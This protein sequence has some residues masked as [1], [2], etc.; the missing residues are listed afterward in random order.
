METLLIGPIGPLIIFVMRIGDVSLATLRMLLIM[1]N[2]KLLAPFIGFFEVMIWLFA[3]GIAIQHLE[4][5]WHVLGYTAGYAAGNWVG[6]W[7]EDRLALGLTSLQVFTPSHGHPIAEVLRE[8]GH[9]VTQFT[10]RGK[11]GRVEVIYSV[12]RRKDARRAMSI[13]EEMDEDAFVTV[14]EVSA[15]HRGWMFPKRRS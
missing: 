14:G 15:I 3:A 12:V 11:A 10:G 13:V 2:R 4:S 8:I 6:L 1:R 9:G 7:L 5:G